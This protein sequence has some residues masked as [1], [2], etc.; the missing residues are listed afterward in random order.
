MSIVAAYNT[1]QGCPP[2]WKFHVLPASS[3]TVFQLG[4]DGIPE[5]E[6]PNKNSPRINTDG[7]VSR[8]RVGSGLHKPFVVAGKNDVAS[9]GMTKAT[10][11]HK[12][13]KSTHRDHDALHFA[14]ILCL[15]TL[16]LTLV[17]EPCCVA[18][19]KVPYWHNSLASVK[20]VAKKPLSL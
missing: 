18:G 8:S 6:R 12:V 5:G 1:A 10:L 2:T 20:C 11:S 9:T 3:R 17:G 13:W 15:C 7:E 16:L 4:E 14:V 19:I